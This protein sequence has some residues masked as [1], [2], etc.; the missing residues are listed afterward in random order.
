MGAC[1]SS[2]QPPPPSDTGPL[3]DTGIP[4]D[5]G[6]MLTCPAN[7]VPD[8]MNQM[9]SCCYRAS[10]ASRLTAPTLRLRYL[11]ITAPAHSALSNATVQT[12]LNNS[13]QNE[14]FN[15]LVR[16]MQTGTGDGPITITTGF[17]TRDAS[18]GNYSFSTM[19][20]YAPVM[21]NGTI[22]GEVVTTQPDPGTLIV[23][24]FDMT[25]MTLEV[26]LQLHN[27]QVV[28]STFTEMRSC[29]GSLGSRGAFNTAATLSGYLTVADTRGSMINV[30]P[31]MAQLCTLVAGPNLTEPSG[32]GHYCDMPQ[33][34][35]AVQPDSLCPAGTTGA[36][37]HDTG[38]TVCSHDGTG[39][40]P[41]N[42]WQL[43][44]DFAAVGVNI[45]P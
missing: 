19:P 2:P 41:C 26:E 14:T 29:I 16:G 31:V 7:M 5:S 24:V 4:T 9:G 42:A 17:G 15:W 25:G 8:Y 32:G 20:R 28:T 21:L 18:T 35:W 30:G 34:M 13:L 39:A 36:C 23:P 12:V 6:T 27:V 43:V 44:S 37:M 38:G 22:M 3:D 45:T 40:T 10:N 33:A 11:H 1:N